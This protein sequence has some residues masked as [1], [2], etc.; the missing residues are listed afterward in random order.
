MCPSADVSSCSLFFILSLTQHACVFSFGEAKHRWQAA[1]PA[2]LLTSGTSNTPRCVNRHPVSPVSSGARFLTVVTRKQ[3]QD[4]KFRQHGHPPSH[5]RRTAVVQPCYRPREL[6]C[7][8]KYEAT[9]LF[10]RCR[11]VKSE[12][13]APRMLY[14]R[15]DM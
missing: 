9:L 11:V 6:A 10:L 13:A 15:A 8:C 7:F 3:S 1:N 12:L 4:L 5:Q 2:R 14:L